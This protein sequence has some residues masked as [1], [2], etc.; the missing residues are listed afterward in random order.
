MRIVRVSAAARKRQDGRCQPL[1]R[2]LR[3]QHGIDQKS[4]GLPRALA[5][6]ITPLK[7]PECPL[8]AFA[9]LGKIR[10]HATPAKTQLSAINPI[11]ASPHRYSSADLTTGNARQK[12]DILK[13]QHATELV[14]LAFLSSDLLHLMEPDRGLA[15]HIAGF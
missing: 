9:C 7:M 12:P 11:V 4:Q 10:M 3:S 5:G 15:A 6:F 8:Q 1:A 2:I 14:S 13:I